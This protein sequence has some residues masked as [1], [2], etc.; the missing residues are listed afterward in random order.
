MRYLAWAHPCREGRGGAGLGI[1]EE[2]AQGTER[3]QGSGPLREGPGGPGGSD[4]LL[5]LTLIPQVT[6]AP[7]LLCQTEGGS[8]ALVGVAVRGSSELFAAVGPE[9]AWVSQTVG[10]AHFLPPSDFP[11][12]PPESSDFCSPELARA[13]GSPRALLFLLFLTPLIQA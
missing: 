5:T 8:W 12:L 2:G 9:K 10:E 6:S 4:A 13:P 3:Y 7:P 11:H 1:W